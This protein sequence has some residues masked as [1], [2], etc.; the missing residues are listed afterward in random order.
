MHSCRSTAGSRTGPRTRA[1]GRVLSGVGSQPGLCIRGLGRVFLGPPFC[2]AAES[3]PF[4][5]PPHLHS[6]IEALPAWIQKNIGLV[7]GRWGE[8]C[9][10]QDLVTAST[11]IHSGGGR[12]AG[13]RDYAC[14]M[15]NKSFVQNSPR[16]ARPKPLF[17]A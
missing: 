10:L 2:S 3:S 15:C 17:R 11:A 4:L 1:S 5:T 13:E 6:D 14:D 12:Q 7:D 16:H 8:G 9:G